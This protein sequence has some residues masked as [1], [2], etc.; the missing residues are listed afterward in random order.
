MKTQK[1]S[2]LVCILLMSAIGASFVAALA[3]A[4]GGFG[5]TITTVQMANMYGGDWVWCG[6]DDCDTA[7]EPNCPG[8]DTCGGSEDTSNCRICMDTAGEQ[9]G[10]PSSWPGWDC[11]NTTASCNY[12]ALYSCS[13]GA[14]FSYTGGPDDGDSC[15]S[16]PDC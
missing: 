4:T 10:Q 9:C 7:A 6:D 11:V 16:R 5:E 1:Y 8:G 14:C 12:P 3:Y 2:T 15:G 13:D